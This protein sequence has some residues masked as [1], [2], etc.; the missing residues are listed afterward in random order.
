[1][2]NELLYVIGG[3]VYHRFR[4]VLRIGGQDLIWFDRDEAGYLLLNVILGSTTD[5]PRGAIIQNNWVGVGIESD[6]E[7]PPSAK[8]VLLRYSN[9]DLM[10]V[11][12][13]EC[14]DSD[15][16][17]TRL[18]H[19]SKRDWEAKIE[20]PITAV[21]ITYR[22]VGAGGLEFTPTESKLPGI[23]ITDAFCTDGDCVFVLG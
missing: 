1:M 4:A 21:N 8:R 19:M 15:T 20:F 6:I 7:C 22:V 3:G 18:P 5:E 9:G 17:K 13:F 12:F 16:L 14:L 10:Q 11:E 2:R 23:S